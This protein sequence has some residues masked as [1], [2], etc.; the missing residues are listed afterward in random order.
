MSK[1][2]RRRQSKQKQPPPKT[3]RKRKS[4]A[5]VL[6]LI[7]CLTAVVF[8]RWGGF[9]AVKIKALLSP[10]PAT[11]SLSPTSPSREYIY[12]GGRL[13]ATEEPASSSLSAPTNLVATAASSTQVSL[14]WN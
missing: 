3:E 13:I 1:R 12:A 14:T 11:P 8:A 4:I 2:R 9:R 10:Q 7:L 5:I 6:G